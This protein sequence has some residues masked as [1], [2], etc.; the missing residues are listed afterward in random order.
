MLLFYLRK[1]K[2]NLK[3]FKI[4]TEF[5]SLPEEERKRLLFEI[6]DIVFS[7]KQRRKPQKVERKRPKSNP[8]MLHY[9]TVDTLSW[10]TKI[11]IDN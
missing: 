1:N 9:L 3:H 4:K 10:S 5:L 11:K 2:R 7:N 8:K 6:F